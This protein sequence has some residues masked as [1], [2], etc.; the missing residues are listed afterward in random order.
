MEVQTQA[1]PK[2][3]KSNIS[4]SRKLRRAVSWMSVGESKS[5]AFRK[6]GFRDSFNGNRALRRQLP[7]IIELLESEG[8]SDKKLVEVLKG[9]L[10]ANKVISATII[11]NTGAD[12]ES[13]GAQA[14]SKTQDFIEVPDWKTRHHYLKT[15]LELKGYTNPEEMMATYSDGETFRSIKV[16][17]R[18]AGELIEDINRRLTASP[19]R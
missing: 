12:S 2:V 10:S 7:Q 9:G 19:H 16:S 3:K 6:A 17:G 18:S 13:P 8:L 14:S 1:K 11:E 15:A 4:I 5:D